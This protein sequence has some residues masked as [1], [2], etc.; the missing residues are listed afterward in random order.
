M[1]EE[2]IQLVRRAWATYTGDFEAFAACLADDWR[3]HGPSGPAGG[4][5]TLE[6][7]RLTMESH[8]IAFPDKHAEIHQILSGR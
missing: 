1:N 2:N 5:G 3:E 7:E 8:R 6:G 4:F